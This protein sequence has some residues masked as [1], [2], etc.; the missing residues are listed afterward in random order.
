MGGRNAAATPRATAEIYKK[1]FD[2]EEIKNQYQKAKIVFGD[3]C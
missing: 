3:N 1:S 2:M